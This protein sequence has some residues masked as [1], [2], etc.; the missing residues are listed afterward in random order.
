MTSAIARSGSRSSI[1]L[2]N[3]SRVVW[4]K[5]R[6]PTGSGSERSKEA[7]AVTSFFSIRGLHCV[8]HLHILASDIG[9]SSL[10]GVICESG[11][12]EKTYQNEQHE[13]AACIEENAISQHT[14]M[15]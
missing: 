9:F 2:V 12:Y 4:A 11:A 6:N 10:A 3:I 15:K 8:S 7:R 5:S 13:R 14:P 1:V